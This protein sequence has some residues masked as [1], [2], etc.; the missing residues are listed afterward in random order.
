MHARVHIHTHIRYNHTRPYLSPSVPNARGEEGKE[1]DRAVTPP[2]SPSHQLMAPT[3][4][5]PPEPSVEAV[6]GG[7]K[8]AK[9]V[10][11][12]KRDLCMKPL[13]VVFFSHRMVL[14]T[15]LSMSLSIPLP[16][17]F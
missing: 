10:E 2:L 5:A 6:E 8:D 4:P 16:L 3:S 12:G 13:L 1:R 17:C 15:P 9:E 7:A 11:R 14:S